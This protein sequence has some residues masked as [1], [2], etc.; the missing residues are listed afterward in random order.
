[1][2]RARADSES[3]GIPTR[4]HPVY[5][6]DI[7]GADAQAAFRALVASPTRHARR[8]ENFPRPWVD[9]VLEAVEKYPVL[10]EVIDKTD[11]R[12]ILNLLCTATNVMGG[13][14]AQEAVKAVIQKNP[15]ALVWG[16]DK[17]NDLLGYLT[18]NTNHTPV[19]SWITKHFPWIFQLDECKTYKPHINVLRRIALDRFSSFDVLEEYYKVYPEALFESF[20]PSGTRPIDFLLHQTIFTQQVYRLFQVMLD[21]CPELLAYSDSFGRSLLYRACERLANNSYS[22]NLDQM[23]RLC[24]LLLERNLGLARV[25]SNSGRLPIL[26]LSDKC[27]RADVQKVMVALLR[28]MYPNVAPHYAEIPF[29]QRILHILKQEAQAALEIINIKRVKTMMLSSSKASSTRKKTSHGTGQSERQAD[30]AGTHYGEWA[31]SRIIKLKEAIKV[32]RDRDIAFVMQTFEVDN[33]E[34]VVQQLA[35]SSDDE[36]D[37][38]ESHGEDDHDSYIVDLSDSD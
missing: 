17:G 4:V 18:V 7:S 29:I 16:M 6:E 14:Y 24:M 33:A 27:H 26:V 11:D 34:A 28:A 3:T 22:R 5:V 30:K 35:S 25:P 23:Y 13:A 9:Q 32:Y 10:T 15:Y 37:G 1:M 20:D 31:D 36:Q 2:K 19:F 8:S 12:S 38:I 21:I